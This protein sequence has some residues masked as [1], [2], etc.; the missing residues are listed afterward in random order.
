MVGAS[1]PPHITSP[2]HEG[3]PRRGVRH[4]SP[5]PRPVNHHGRAPPVPLPTR[6]VGGRRDYEDLDLDGDEEE[7][8]S[9]GT[10]RIESDNYSRLEREKSPVGKISTKGPPLPSRPH[11]PPPTPKPGDQ[12]VQVPDGLYASI[13]KPKK[14]MAV[15]VHGSRPLPPTMAPK[16]P[17]SSL[18]GSNPDLSGIGLEEYGKLDRRPAPQQLYEEEYNTLDHVTTKLNGTSPERE[19]YG[20]LDRTG[21]SKVVGSGAGGVPHIAEQYGKLELTQTNMAAIPSSS[22]YEMMDDLSPTL[23]SSGVPAA[24]PL[25][26][27]YGKLQHTSTSSNSAAA[28]TTAAATPRVTKQRGE[29]YGRLER[30]TATKT[31]VPSTPEDEYGHL[32]T[33]PRTSSFNPYGT[34]APEGHE[35]GEAVRDRKD[36]KTAPPP[37]YENAEFKEPSLA[38]RMSVT[39]SQ[40]MSRPQA[41]PRAQSTSPNLS[42]RA[43][44]GYVNVDDKGKVRKVS[45]PL[46][47]PKPSQLD[48]KSE[49]FPNSHDTSLKSHDMNGGTTA[50]YSACKLKPTVTSSDYEDTEKLDFG[51]RPKPMSS[52]HTQTSSSTNSVPSMAPPPPAP[53]KGVSNRNATSSAN[54]IDLVDK[55]SVA[56]KPPVLK[57]KPTNIH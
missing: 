42:K 39:S 57:L 23:S 54:S 27:T 18:S 49:N 2:E 7:M 52:L 16:P 3:G 29:E 26:E 1:S 25:H 24:T 31:S 9:N 22:H 12:P 38:Y 8:P 5:T 28:N 4:T 20:K 41:P 37:G 6:K 32:E 47:R 13:N 45:P 48:P 21:R 15:T 36:S 51:P 46:P 30:P 19:E 11:V 14:R 50:Y 55:P 34:L 53:R 44:S 56:R 40:L 35:E 33:R 17:P 43:H 10:R